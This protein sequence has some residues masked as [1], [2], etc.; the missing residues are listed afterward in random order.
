MTKAI[1]RFVYKRKYHCSRQLM[2]LIP[3]S[4]LV[5]DEC[6]LWNSVHFSK[7]RHAVSIPESAVL[8]DRV[9]S[10]P[11][12]LVSLFLKVL[13]TRP[14][15]IKNSSHT[16]TKASCLEPPADGVAVFFFVFLR[17]TGSFDHQQFIP[18]HPLSLPFSRTWALLYHSHSTM[19]SINVSMSNF[20][21][22]LSS[23]K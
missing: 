22:H 3:F 5:I 9:A 12:F 18:Q 1:E 17:G 6:E 13:C 16:R 11:K 14:R 23:E 10:I 4:I 7:P 15:P 2:D 19:C 21:P 8:G 20:G